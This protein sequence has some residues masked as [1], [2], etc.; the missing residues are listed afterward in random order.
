MNEPH[1]KHPTTD[2]PLRRTCATLH[3]HQQLLAQSEHYAQQRQ[4]IEAGYLQNVMLARVEQ[5]DVISIPV[6]V[7]VLWNKPEQNISDEQIASQMIVLNQDFRKQNPDISQ[8]PPVWEDTAED[9]DIEFHL[10]TVD[11]EGLPTTGITRTHTSKEQFSAF[12]D[13]VKTSA[14]GG[15]DAWPSDQYLNI[16]VCALSY[17]LL[18]YAQFPGGPAHTDGVVVTYK[19]FGTTGTAEAP[20][21]LGRTLTHEVGHWLDLRHI[22]GDDGME[23]GTECTGTDHV[24]DTPNQ[25]GPNF[26]TPSFPQI[27]CNNGPD[28]DMFMNFMDYVNDSAMVMF[29][30][31]QVERMH[32]CLQGPRSSFLSSPNFPESKELLL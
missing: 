12:E 9:A 7:H 28:G 31:E 4:R 26:G 24:D 17:G 2:L 23:P 16:W 25:D 21:N 8:V 10:A 22:W 18:G 15:I 19:A 29:T 27:S 20:F 11:P 1:A 3:V 32:A 13:D 30:D 6:V 5:R 14:T